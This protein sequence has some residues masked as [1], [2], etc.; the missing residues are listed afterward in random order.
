MRLEDATKVTYVQNLAYPNFKW[1]TSIYQQTPL[2]SI[3]QNVKM[4]NQYS[5]GAEL[6]F[7]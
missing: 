3:K 4:D 1:S 5:T 2:F 6:N 7:N